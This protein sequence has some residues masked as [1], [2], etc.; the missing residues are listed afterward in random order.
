MIK[1]LFFADVEGIK[2]FDAKSLFF[3]EV[4]I[5]VKHGKRESGDLSIQ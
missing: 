3:K 2:D 4:E 1:L 5:S